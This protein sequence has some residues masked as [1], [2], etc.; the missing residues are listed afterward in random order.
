MGSF[1]HLTGSHWHPLPAVSYSARAVL[2]RSA[3][4]GLR[5]SAPGSLIWSSPT[6]WHPAICATVTGPLSHVSATLPFRTDECICTSL[7]FDI[8]KYSS[9]VHF[10]LTASVFLFVQT[11]HLLCKFS[12]ES[13]IS[14]FIYWHELYILVCLLFNLGVALFLLVGYFHSRR[15]EFHREVICH[16]FYH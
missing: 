13:F 4:S 7:I 15:A 10:W 5:W 11:F 6:Q 3:C 14:V 12:V 9:T 16:C 1:S 2:P 8:I